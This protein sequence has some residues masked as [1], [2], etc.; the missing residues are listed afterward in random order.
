MAK[1]WREFE[2]LVA[3]IE[4]HLAP[5]GATVKSPDRLTD[6]FTGMS[7]EVDAAIRFPLG[8]VPILITIECRDREDREDVTW[9][10][11]LATKRHHVGATATIAVSSEGFSE[12]A[13]KAAG[14]HGIET[15]II[16]EMPVPL[17]ARTR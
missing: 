14:V 1:P 4:G 8:S 13:I 2:L 17:A 12:P 15:R 6:K 7:R 3:R 9:I 16:G 10:E 5:L 11:Q